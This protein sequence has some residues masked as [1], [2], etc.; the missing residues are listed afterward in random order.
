M[1]TLHTLLA[2]AAFWL[3]ACGP[4]A[5]PTP[6][7]AELLDRAAQAASDMQSAQFT[8]MREGA[9]VVL[10]PATNTTFTEASGK[11]QAPD[12]VSA[13][14]KISLLGNALQIQM[15]WLP[16]GNYVTHPLT[17][18]W[19]E[20][21]ADATFN[22]A[23]LFGADGLPAL[24]KDGIQKAALVGMERLEER[25]TYHLHGEADGAQLATLTAGALAAGTAYPVDVW[26]EVEASH[27]VRVHI[28]EP[29][30]S[31]WLIDLFAINEPVEINAP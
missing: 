9:A 17:Q 6:T 15:L 8:L 23:A 13:T 22:G 5:A 29:D 12:R 24:L 11:Y 18:A 28:S 10:D 1:K 21:P 20:A 19:S 7:P 30:G 26:M 16:E 4:R 3:A 14:V 27:L 25:D 2:L 31:G